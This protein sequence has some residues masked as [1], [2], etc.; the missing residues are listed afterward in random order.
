MQLFQPWNKWPMGTFPF[1]ASTPLTH[2]PRKKPTSF[3]IPLYPRS[4]YFLL[5]PGPLC[6]VLCLRQSLK[7]QKGKAGKKW[8]C[9]QM[10]NTGFWEEG[11]WT[12]GGG[13]GGNTSF[14]S[15]GCARDWL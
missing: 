12:E 4:P 9:K 2:R 3:I 1:S 7:R 13:V 10:V 5:L 14:T 6:F 11:N 15:F 8:K